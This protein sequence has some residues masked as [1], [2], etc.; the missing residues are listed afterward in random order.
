MHGN[1][2]IVVGNGSA[3]QGVG[4]PLNQAEGRFTGCAKCQ[5]RFCLAESNLYVLCITNSKEM[6]YSTNLES[7]GVNQTLEDLSLNVH[8]L[9][10]QDSQDV[11]KLIESVEFDSGRAAKDLEMN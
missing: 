3:C 10:C 6:H 7:V 2:G 9:D 4:L 5:K 11:I 8:S 1:V